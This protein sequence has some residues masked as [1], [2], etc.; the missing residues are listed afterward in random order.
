MSTGLPIE[1]NEDFQKKEH[2]FENIGRLL[3][4]A[5]T[6]LG[7]LGL[8]GNGLFSTVEKGLSDGSLRYDRFGRSDSE[9]EFIFVLDPKSE[10]FDIGLGKGFL[11]QVMSLQVS[12]PAVISPEPDGTYYSFASS[13]DKPLTVRFSYRPRSFGTLEGQFMIE[14][15]ETLRVRQFIYP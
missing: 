9:M 4:I 5:F 11:Q 15:D 14:K 8:F 3:L 7:V 6:L 12:P 10:R 2:V 1:Q 13:D